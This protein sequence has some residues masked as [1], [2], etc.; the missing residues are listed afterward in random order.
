[1]GSVI[2]R[3]AV[4]ERAWEA[5]AGGAAVVVG[6]PAGIGKTAVWRALVER[7]RA[8]GWRVPA[9]APAES[10]QAL[11]L[12]AL[13]DLVQPLAEHVPGLPAPQRAAAEVV[14]HQAEP[15]TTADERALGAA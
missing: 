3:D 13:A 5:L 14:L 2:G 10:E 11:P 4:L 9:C 15:G 1:M 7:A 6:G 8:E 12:A